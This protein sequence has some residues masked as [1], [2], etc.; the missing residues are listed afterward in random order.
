MTKMTQLGIA[1]LLGLTAFTLSA[2]TLS[3]TATL[4]ADN[5]Y[6]LYTGLSDAS[7]L[8]F[9]GRNE[10]GSNGSTGGYNWSKPETWSV[11]LE[12]GQHLYVLAWD[13]G[14]PQSWIGEFNFGSSTL[15]SGA[16]TWE[17]TIAT[18]A[19]PGT[20]GD[21]PNLAAVMEAIE[22]GIWNPVTF[23]VANGTS[24]WGM[25][26]DIDAGAKFIAADG[27]GNSVP[28]DTHY[29]IYRNVD[30]LVAATSTPVPEAGTAVAGLALAL[31]AG[32]TARRRRLAARQ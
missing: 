1:G 12:A 23:E 8:S 9:I 20:N 30:P 4:T 19:N 6:G 15:Y 10:K 26:P 7:D 13:D 27:F 28:S 25:I 29:V 21:V 32:A 3:G 5:H 16:T 31:L 17:Y 11:S 18:G 24:P 2:N 14:G 22:T